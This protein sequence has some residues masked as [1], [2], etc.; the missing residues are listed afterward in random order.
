[1]FPHSPSRS[2]EG[3]YGH[4]YSTSA[5]LLGFPLFV[6]Q[7][8]LRGFPRAPLKNSTPH[9]IVSNNIHSLSHSFG[10]QKLKIRGAVLLSKLV[11][12][13]PSSPPLASGVDWQP[14]CPLACRD[15]T[16]IS[17]SIATSSSPCVCVS[18]CLHMA[19]FL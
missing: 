12:E 15:I 3:K 9:W 8:P 2:Q 19:I 7:K 11:G 1:M 6:F 14:R 16:P 18:L 17:A 13:N 5:F 4:R 10:G